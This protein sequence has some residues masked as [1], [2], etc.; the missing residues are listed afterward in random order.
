M[1]IG[2]TGGMGCGKSTAAHAM[3]ARGCRLIDSDDIIRREILPDPAVIGIARSRWGD[4]VVDATGQLDRPGAEPMVSEELTTVRLAPGYQPSLLD[5]FVPILVLMG[6]AIVPYLVIPG[7]RDSIAGKS[8]PTSSCDCGNCIPIWW[9]S[10]STTVKS[11]RS[12]PACSV[13]TTASNCWPELP[14]A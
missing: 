9:R 3:A 1:I 8:T 4:D 11:W 14:T 10:R 6:V 2:V 7:S 12:W 5:F 13:A